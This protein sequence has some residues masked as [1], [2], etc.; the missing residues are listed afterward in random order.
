MGPS[1][2]PGSMK[3]LTLQGIGGNHPHMEAVWAEQRLGQGGCLAGSL[4]YNSHGD[5]AHVGACELFSIRDKGLAVPEVGSG[6]KDPGSQAGDLPD[7][8]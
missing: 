4:A 5:V 2:D 1:F 6:K 8:L 3:T 7:C